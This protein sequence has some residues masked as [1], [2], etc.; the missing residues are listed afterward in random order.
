MSR[1]KV[2]DGITKE[3][4]KPAPE[5]LETGVEKALSQD[6]PE[7][8]TAETL[9]KKDD[10]F[11]AL[12][13]RQEIEAEKTEAQRNE[14]EEVS[15]RIQKYVE[16]GFDVLIHDL[17]DQTKGIGGWFNPKKEINEEIAKLNL[18][19]ADFLKKSMIPAW[20]VIMTESRFNRSN[21]VNVSLETLRDHIL[22][23][24]DLEAYEAG[25]KNLGKQIEPTQVK[26]SGE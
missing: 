5:V 22:K 4:K 6:F 11:E 16:A 24:Q 21:R 2:F 9:V 18:K 12:K 17:E 15:A 13:L 8:D 7:I 26:L 23:P 14:K 1:E 3:V 19:K 25:L 10:K 20:D